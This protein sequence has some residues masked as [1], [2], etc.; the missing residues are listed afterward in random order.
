MVLSLVAHGLLQCIVKAFSCHIMG[1]G[2][3]PNG[4][5][6][7]PDAEETAF[8]WLMNLSLSEEPISPDNLP[9]AREEHMS[10]GPTTGT[11][12]NSDGTQETLLQTLALP[13]PAMISEVPDWAQP[14]S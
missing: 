10:S 5:V 12:R 9:F 7:P 2:H 1:D 11:T 8:A 6:P 13:L 3:T 4:A 14:L